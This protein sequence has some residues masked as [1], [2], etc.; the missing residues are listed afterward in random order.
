MLVP[1]MRKC[2]LSNERVSVDGM[3]E[4]DGVGREGKSYRDTP[5]V[6]RFDLVFKT[7]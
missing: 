5:F 2:E 6:I 3:L 4:H 7:S 1:E